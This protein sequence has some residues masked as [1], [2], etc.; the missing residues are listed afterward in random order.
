QA[1][2]GGGTGSR[3]GNGQGRGRGRGR[4]R[5]GRPPD[6][7]PEATE[8]TVRSGR[9]T[10]WGGSSTEVIWRIDETAIA[11]GYPIGDERLD[12]QVGGGPPILVTPEQVHDMFDHDDPRI[13]LLLTR[14]TDIV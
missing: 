12:V 3:S 2:R 4:R 10:R 1:G 13:T 11:R 9:T 5:K 14:G 7:E 6:V 8:R